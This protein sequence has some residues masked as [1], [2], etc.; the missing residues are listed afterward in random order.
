MKNAPPRLS[1]RLSPKRKLIAVQV[2]TS[3]GWG[4]HLLM[5]IFHYKN[6]QPD[7]DIWTTPT[8]FA[9]PHNLPQGL[10][11]DGAI[12]YIGNE[13]QARNMARYGIPVVSV[14]VFDSEPFGIPN[15]PPDQDAPI[16]LAFSFFHRRGYRHFA[17]CGPIRTPHVRLYAVKLRDRARAA[18]CDCAILDVG[19]KG[20]TGELGSLSLPCAVLAWPRTVYQVLAACHALNLRIPEELPILTQAD[21]DILNQLSSPPLSAIRVP[22]ERIGQEAARMLHLMMDGQ[23]LPTERPIPKPR[24]II[25][26]QSTNALAIEDEEIRTALHFIRKHYHRPYSVDDIA[27]LTGL[28]RRTLERRF[29]K[30]FGRTVAEEIKHTRLERAREMLNETDLPVADIAPRCGFSSAEYFIYVFRQAHKVTPVA[31]RNRH[32]GVDL[33]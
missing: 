18:G 22:T 6:Q 29:R 23:P 33:A 7:W 27:E 32:R 16:D 20:F 8:S 11:F 14:S 26:R 3:T 31:F 25:E 24:D 10:V 9:E 30:L 2:D 1:K 19:A 17:Y 15:I 12:A 5:G 21:D 4:R 13:K 28:S